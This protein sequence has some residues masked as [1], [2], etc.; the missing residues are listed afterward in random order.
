MKSTPYVN[1]REMVPDIG[2]AAFE[3]SPMLLCN[4]AIP[5]YSTLFGTVVETHML[6]PYDKRVDADLQIHAGQSWKILIKIIRKNKDF[7]KRKS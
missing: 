3:D 1:I 2:F 4:R 7:N 5:A 6:K